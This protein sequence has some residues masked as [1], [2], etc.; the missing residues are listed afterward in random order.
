MNTMSTSNNNN[1][2]SSSSGSIALKPCILNTTSSSSNMATKSNLNSVSDSPVADPGG[3]SSKVRLQGL[4]LC[5]VCWVKLTEEVKMFL[6]PRLF[7]QLI[8]LQAL[9]HAKKLNL[10]TKYFIAPIATEI[11]SITYV[12]QSPA[13]YNKRGDFSYVATVLQVKWLTFAGHV[14]M[15][16]ARKMIFHQKWWIFIVKNYIYVCCVRGLYTM[17]NSTD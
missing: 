13:I 16:D 8:W 5:C 15:N 17:T 3:S 12:E 1:G 2:G 10:R 11:C 14:F 7:L 6:D 4:C 9:N